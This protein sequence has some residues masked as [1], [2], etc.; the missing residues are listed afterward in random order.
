MFDEGERRVNFMFDEE[1]STLPQTFGVLD[2]TSTY[3]SHLHVFI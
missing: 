3:I 1:E 2:D